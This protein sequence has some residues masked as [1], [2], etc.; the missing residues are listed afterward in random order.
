MLRVQRWPWLPL[1]LKAPWETLRLLRI[2]MPQ[3]LNKA[4]PELQK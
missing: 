2:R 1:K 4:Q 3:E